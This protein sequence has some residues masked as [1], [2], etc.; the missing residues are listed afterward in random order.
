MATL[1]QQ[2]GNLIAALEHKKR[3]LDEAL[4]TK[5]DLMQATAERTIEAQVFKG[6]NTAVQIAVPD[7]LRI[8]ED[9]E[10]TPEGCGV[11]RVMTPKDGDKR[12]VWDCRDMNQIEEAK[13]MFDKLIQEGLVPYKV[14]LDGKATSEVMDEFDP[15]AEEILF[16]PIAL[17][18]GG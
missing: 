10:N 12:I 2:I 7:N 14:G 3:T 17:V 11:F 18:T 15:H 4:V 13:A 9:H 6:S 1:K 5:G 8:L 16:L